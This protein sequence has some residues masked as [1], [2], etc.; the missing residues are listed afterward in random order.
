MQR[1]RVYEIVNVLDR[2]GKIE[3]LSTITD[4]R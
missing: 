2:N 1:W 3:R 4:P